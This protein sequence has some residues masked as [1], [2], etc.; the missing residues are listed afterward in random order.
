MT[1]S[2]ALVLHLLRVAG[3]VCIH[4]GKEVRCARLCTNIRQ[5][6][7]FKHQLQYFQY[8]KS[9]W[10]WKPTTW[11]FD[12][13]WFCFKWSGGKIVHCKQIAF[14]GSLANLK[15]ICAG[16]RVHTQKCSKGA[17]ISNICELMSLQTNWSGFSLEMG[18]L[19]KS[20]G[21]KITSI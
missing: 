15:H 10:I 17:V 1:C 11:L 6:C 7:E 19:M 12:A 9:A 21:R 2:W 14:S 3:N 20:S 5:H 8:F 4:L 13:M 16:V 18:V